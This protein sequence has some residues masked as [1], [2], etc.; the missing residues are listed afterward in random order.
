VNHLDVTFIETQNFIKSNLPVKLSLDV[1]MRLKRGLQH[2]LSIQPQED[3]IRALYKLVIVHAT[4]SEVA[5]PTSGLIFLKLF[6]GNSLE[7]SDQTTLSSKMILESF[8]KSDYDRKIIDILTTTLLLVSA[9]TKISIKKSTSNK[10]YIELVDGYSFNCK[11]LMFIKPTELSRAKVVCIDGFIESVS[12]IHHLLEHLALTKIPCLLFSRGMSNDVLHTLKVNND[13]QSLIAL[14]YVVPFDPENVNVLVDLAVV[15]GT[16]VSSS[17]KGSLISSIQLDDVPFVDK[18]TLSGTS[19]SIK[20]ESTKKRTHDHIKHLNEVL[21]ER[22]EIDSIL[23]SRLKSL[24]SSCIDIAI[25]DDIDFFRLSSQLDEGLRII[26]TLS[27]SAYDPFKTAS[28][29]LD[30]FMKLC[31]ELSLSTF[32]YSSCQSV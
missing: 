24:S 23:S 6:A 17:H 20:N 28:D 4:K 29:F 10:S 12:E 25:P 16:D 13:R 21:I 18:I 14:P 11:P 1:S 26:R 2:F 27:S 31:K 9:S 22:P 5:C 7:T 19:I 3:K 15:C 32:I 30:S 8:R